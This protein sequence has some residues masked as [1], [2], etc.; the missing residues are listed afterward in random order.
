[1]D[2]AWCSETNSNLVE[3]LF[4]VLRRLTVPFQLAGGFLMNANIV[5]MTC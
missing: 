2:G 4:R 5:S 1:M 3:L